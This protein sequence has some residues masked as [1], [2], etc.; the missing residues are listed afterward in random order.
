MASTLEDARAY[1]ADV[2]WQY[3]KTMAQWPHEYTVREWRPDREQEFFEFVVLIRRDGIAKAVATRCATAALP[4][5]IPGTR[6]L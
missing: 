2:R 3:P 4:P 5:Q 1:V 6:R